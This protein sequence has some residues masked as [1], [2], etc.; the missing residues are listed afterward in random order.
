MP[1]GQIA[2][3]LRLERLLG[4]RT[5]GSTS[6][7]TVMSAQCLFGHVPVDGGHRSHR[8]AD[9]PHGVVEEVAA[10]LR[11]ALDLVVV[12]LA[13]GDGTGAPD[14]LRSSRA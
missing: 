10:L 9:E 11:D 12:L 13:A 5:N 6:Y 3:A 14:D 4:S 2:T 8:I 7:S 1:S